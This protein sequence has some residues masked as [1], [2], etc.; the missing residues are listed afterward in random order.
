[1]RKLLIGV[2]AGLM[3]SVPV[4][5][6]RAG[7]APYDPKAAMKSFKALQDAQWKSL[8]HQ[9][10]SQKQSWK[11]TQ[12]TKAARQQMNHQMEH[13]RRQ[14]RE[15]LRNEM[16]AWKDRDRMTNGNGH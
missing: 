2:I 1:M 8:I 11:G 13:E 12:M 4:V 7:Q 3:L 5:R 9:Q 14:L 16:Q 10:K 6:A 15:K